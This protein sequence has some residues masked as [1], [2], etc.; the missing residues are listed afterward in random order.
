MAGHDPMLTTLFLADRMIRD[1]LT[2]K[3][4]A[5]GLHCGFAVPEG[6][7]FPVVVPEVGFFMR[8]ADAPDRVALYGQIISPSGVVVQTSAWSFDRAERP[9][10]GPPGLG[11]WWEIGG[12]FKDVAL[13]QRGRY[14][15]EMSMNGTTLGETAM[16][17]S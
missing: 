1:Q 15:V 4:G 2:Q 17:V 16:Y 9:E 12:R 5:L 8:V 11:R 3:W 6:Q 10:G 7:P 14:S 13:T